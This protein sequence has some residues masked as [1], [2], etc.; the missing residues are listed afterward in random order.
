MKIVSRRGLP[1]DTELE[2]GIGSGE[3]MTGVFGHSS[4]R[5][6]D[7]FGEEVNRAA[8]IGYHRGIAITERVYDAVKGH[9][10]TRRLPN[11]SVKWQDEPLQVW[12]VVNGALNEGQD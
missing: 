5:Q 11:F 6:K 8:T 1:P 12:E 9:Y 10:K 7:V 4:L 3:V 2:V